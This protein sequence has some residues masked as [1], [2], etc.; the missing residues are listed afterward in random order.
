MF[1][2]FNFSILDSSLKKIE[3]I[4]EGCL[5]HDEMADC[6]LVDLVLSGS[7]LQVFVDTDEGINF[8]QC[9]KLSRQ[10]ESILD[11]SLLLGEKYT[12][13]VSSP[14]ISR[15]LKF[16]RQY[17][18]NIGREIEITMLDASIIKGTLKNVEDDLLTVESPGEKKK[19]TIINEIR[20]DAVNSSKISISFGKQKM[21]K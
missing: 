5:S 1:P 2:L 20:F 4:I 6:F 11:E 8:K 19:E 3:E 17:P 10:I 21:K 16:L 18:R 13:E 7:K 9:Q 15:P 12:L 14:G